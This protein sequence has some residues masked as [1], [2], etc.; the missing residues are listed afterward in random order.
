M[1]NNAEG[2]AFSGLGGNA[3]GNSSLGIVGNPEGKSIKGPEIKTEGFLIGKV[4]AIFE[5]SPVLKGSK[6]GLEMVALNL[7]GKSLPA[8]NN[9]EG[10]KGFGLGLINKLSREEIKS[11]LCP[12]GLPRLPISKGVGFLF[13]TCVFNTSFLKNVPSS[14]NTLASD[15]SG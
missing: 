9:E 14:A 2:I 4:P 12:E 10:L 11:P 7:E 6:E 5:T 8:L 15:H 13:K 1:G 3:D